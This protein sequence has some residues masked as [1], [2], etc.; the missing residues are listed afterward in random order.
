VKPSQDRLLAGI[1]AAL[2]V[3]SAL[4]VAG[5]VLPALLLSRTEER[6]RTRGLE[7]R[8]CASALAAAEELHRIQHGQ[9]AE[10]PLALDPGSLRPCAGMEIRGRAEGPEGYRFVIVHNGM[11]LAVTE[12]Y[13]KTPV[14][15][16]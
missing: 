12:E 7:V 16:R 15:S 4:F 8:L 9:W 5:V 3:A 2:T 11:L 1:L 10:T 6:V 14:S 13:L